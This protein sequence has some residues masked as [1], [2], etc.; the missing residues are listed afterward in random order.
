M[1]FDI[2]T[3]Y[4]KKIFYPHHRAKHVQITR[5]GEFLT[6][7]EKVASEVVKDSSGQYKLETKAQTVIFK[8][9]NV[10]LASGG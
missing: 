9:R 10:V 1:L 5:N 7:V 3:R 4:N 6:T 2:W 8:S